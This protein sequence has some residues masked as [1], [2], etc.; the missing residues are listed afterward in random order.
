MVQTLS[1][2][3]IGVRD[4]NG[5]FSLNDCHKAS[6]G[7]PNHKPPFFLRTDQAK[8]LIRELE[9][10]ADSQLVLRVVHGNAGGTYACRE[11]VIAYAA[12]ISAAFHLKVIRVFLAASSSSGTPAQ[13]LEPRL[14]D[15]HC[16]QIEA[17]INHL[18]A[19]HDFYAPALREA[20]LSRF[21]ARTYLDI[22]RSSFQDVINL[23]RNYAPGPTM[24]RN[25][26]DTVV[27]NAVTHQITITIT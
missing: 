14:D 21:G 26:A 9:R 25:L 4:L 1:I 12:W 23:L 7:K 24:A 2:G 27:A 19:K 17:V 3:A 22:P 20:I 5:L 6:G 10:V 16:Q 15:L 11:L 18:R 13:S 8:E